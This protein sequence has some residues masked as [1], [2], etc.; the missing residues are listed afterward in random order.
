MSENQLRQLLKTVN[1]SDPRSG[2]C[3][4]ENVLAAYVLGAVGEK[5]R[6]SLE[7]HFADCSSCLNAI[8]FLRKSNEWPSDV[9]VP[10]H[11][12]VRAR[13]L[14]EPKPRTFWRWQWVT[15]AATAC[16]LIVAMF[17]AWRVR[18]SQRTGPEDLVA[19][20]QPVD[21]SVK[22]SELKETPT[23]GPSKQ[24]K[25]SKPSKTKT[26]VVR[27]EGSKLGPFLISPRNDAELKTGLLT[28]RWTAIADVSFY[29][30]KIVSA[31]GALV[32]SERTN[33]TELTAT[34][35]PGAKYFVKVVATL[36]DNRST[37][38]DLVSF[39]VLAP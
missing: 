24:P 13:S 1:N 28:V 37:V 21:Q 23:P 19:E 18:L 39:S 22:L 7:T 20:N 2:R 4:D 12:L 9:Q 16:V 26:P 27:G 35:K 32:L 3:P 14:V 8:A 33:K 29:E 10:G 34:L 11:L 36:S 6:A 25:E 5:A 17:A 30:V 31:D 15:A 38:S